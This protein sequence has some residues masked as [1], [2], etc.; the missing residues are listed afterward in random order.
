[1]YI[2]KFPVSFLLYIATKKAEQIITV[3]SSTNALIT[4]NNSC[5]LCVP[6]FL[7]ELAIL[8]CNVSEDSMQ[9]VRHVFEDI[10]HKLNLP[11]NL[12]VENFALHEVMRYLTEIHLKHCVLVV[13]DET[14]K[15]AYDKLHVYEGKQEYEDLLRTAARE[16]GKTDFFGLE[17][18]EKG[19]PLPC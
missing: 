6:M 5:T 19:S 10:G 3:N 7:L 17:M 14:V 8:G 1:M 18:R 9:A 11:A 13:D 15:D 12:P 2:H 16:V 4:K